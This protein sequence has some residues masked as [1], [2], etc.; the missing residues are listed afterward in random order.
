MSGRVE[1]DGAR[2]RAVLSK[3]QF[4]AGL[5]GTE[6]A[7]RIGFSYPQ[8]MRYAHGQTPI[9]PDQYATFAAAYGISEVDL[10]A[11][12]AGVDVFEDLRNVAPVSQSD[13]WSFRAALRGHIPESLIDQM[14]PRW[15]SRPII[16][17]QA[18]V[19]AILEMAQELRDEATPACMNPGHAHAV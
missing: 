3:L 6:A 8:A 14:A 7:R 13:R 15:E 16:D 19:E 2:Q 9:R 10:A 1:F 18:A 5:D 17:Q 12:L 11:E 4:R